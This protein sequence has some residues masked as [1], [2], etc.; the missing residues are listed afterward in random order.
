MICSLILYIIRPLP[1]R[2]IYI[3]WGRARPPRKTDTSVQG[4]LGYPLGTD[5][6]GGRYC[7]LW[8]RFHSSLLS[9]L[10]RV[11]WKVG[12]RL[13]TLLKNLTPVKRS[14]K[15]KQGYWKEGCA[16]RS[17]RHRGQNG[18]LLRG[19]RGQPLRCPPWLGCPPQSVAAPPSTARQTHAHVT[20]G[21]STDDSQPWRHRPSL[22]GEAVPLH[23][24]SNHSCEET[25][26]NPLKKERKKARTYPRHS[27]TYLFFNTKQ[28]W[29]GIPCVGQSPLETQKSVPA[30]QGGN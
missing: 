14:G 26:R 28:R 30:C 15:S 20:R 11:M 2:W 18:K 16:F 13:Y 25:Q 8:I 4:R 6:L 5:C 10:A 22:T 17:T 29:E 9:S 27:F 3:D 12:S 7:H 24:C 19:P 21:C 1:G 23:I